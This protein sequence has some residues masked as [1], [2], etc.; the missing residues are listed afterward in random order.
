MRKRR[1]G[2]TGLQ[3]SEIGFGGWA[4]G[5]NGY[6]PVRDEDSLAALEAAWES[7]INFYDT[8][9]SYGNGHS[10]TL[11]GSFLKGKPRGEIVIATK[12]GHNFYQGAVKKDFTP[13]HLQKA[14]EESLKRLGTDHID[15]YQLHTPSLDILRRGEAV[16]ALVKLQNEGK[17][18]FIGVSVH[19][20]NE[21]MAALQNP[22]IAALQVVFNLLDQRMGRVVFPDARRSDVGI[23][24]REPLACG[25]LTG[26]YNVRST[27]DKTDHRAGWPREK[28]ELDLK[29]IDMLHRVLATR[30]I[31]MAR[32]SLEYVLEHDTIATAIPGMKT[33]DQVEENIQASL[34]PRLRSQESSQLRDMY[35]R[36]PVFEEGLE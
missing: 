1:L 20:E 15:L 23:I 12:G 14:C 2:K 35:M 21:A 24:V 33:A 34:D 25:L 5:G 30:R 29:K 9:D 16:E 18:R 27:F 8:A 32:S 19:A 36:E 28:L 11:I 26:K 10:E 6:G 13:E 31:S 7:G 17:L 4:I 22:A 3:V